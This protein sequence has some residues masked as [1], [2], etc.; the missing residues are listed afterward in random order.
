MGDSVATI[1]VEPR[2]LVRQALVS[3]MG[4][5]SYRVVHSVDFVAQLKGVALKDAPKLVIV[6]PL[7]AP[8]AA[9]EVNYIRKLWP[10]TKVALLAE[11]PSATE[12]EILLGMPID[13]CVPLSVSCDTLLRALDLIMS[14]EHR[15]LVLDPMNDAVAQLIQ[16]NPAVG[17]GEVPREMQPALVE[18][19]AI[20]IKA[21]ISSASPLARTT[22]SERE[23]QI[24]KMLAEGH[25]NKL[26]ARRC[27]LTEA[28]IK[29]HMKSILRKLRVAN[30]T[31]AALWAVQHGY[32]NAR[33]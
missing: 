3:M 26:I 19:K 31:Q 32:N 4:K 9:A 22:L 28:T 33:A 6:G 11:Y 10:D 15:V 27:D 24:I 20:S 13:G 12:R 2:H 17:S 14:Q 16:H 5:H 7:A 18:S 23:G 30:R 21:A 1:L 25:P 29:V 8:D